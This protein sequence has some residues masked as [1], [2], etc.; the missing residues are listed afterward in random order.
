LTA[1][2]LT[3]GL[4]AKWKKEN[5]GFTDLHKYL[6]KTCLEDQNR[7]NEKGKKSRRTKGVG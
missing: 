2:A 1:V 3:K 6:K 5:K 7:Q 4:C